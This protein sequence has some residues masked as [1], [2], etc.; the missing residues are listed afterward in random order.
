MKIIIKLITT[1]S[2]LH[3]QESKLIPQFIDPNACKRD[4]LHVEGPFTLR[5]RL[6]LLLR[7]DEKK[8]IPD[9]EEK[10]HSPSLPRGR[11]VLRDERW[12]QSVK[13]EE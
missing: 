5:E 7:E 4:I 10:C 1:G 13:P 2:V 8:M 11:L 3:S 6:T 9:K 12:P